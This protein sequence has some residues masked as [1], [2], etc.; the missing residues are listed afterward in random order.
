M[1]L[2]DVEDDVLETDKTRLAMFIQS[3]PVL[4]ARSHERTIPT[5]NRFPW[6]NDS[7][8]RTIPTNVRLPWTDDSHEQKF[9]AC[10]ENYNSNRHSQ[11]HLKH[12]SV[13]GVAFIQTG[14]DADFK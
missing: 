11:R 5:N 8:E 13:Y 6:T 10:N 9:T 7:H 2:W 3:T 4:Q 12:N 1:E 14:F